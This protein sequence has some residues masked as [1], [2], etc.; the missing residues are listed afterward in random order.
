[1]KISISREGFY[2]LFIVLMILVGSVIREVNPMLLFAAFLCAPLVIAWRL[3]RRSLRGLQVRR[4]LPMQIFAGEPFIVHLE[5]TNPK[6]NS[7]WSLSSWGIVVVD[8]IQ[9]LY[10]NS[11]EKQEK[12]KPYEPAVYFEYIPNG[13][14]RK[15]SY[16][17][18]LPQRGRYKIGPA[19]ISTRFPF[20]FFRH[21]MEQP[22]TNSE[23]T[24]F[25]VYPKLGKLSTQWKTRQHEANEN[26]QRNR[27]RPTRVSGEFLGVRGWQR[28]D[29]KR[30]IHWRAWA[31]HQE[32]VV[33]QFEQNQ[34]RDC[35]VLIDLYQQGEFN[36][37]QRENFELA[38]SFT[39]TL[40]SELTRRGGC[41]L[42]FST[43][44]GYNDYLYGLICLP[45]VES[46]LYRLAL[47][48]PSREDGLAQTLFKAI[49]Q[50]DP[51]AELI[52]ITPASFN[53]LQSPRFQE[54]QAD[55]RFRSLLQRIRV[56]DTSSNDLETI[57]SV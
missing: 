7:W 4:I 42:F 13:Q 12:I 28:G 46:I 54:Y 8:R 47:A 19:M 35:A 14:T 38:I 34:N 15:K 9:P 21:W 57:F 45:I 39:A 56:I 1:M 5:A 49:S 23:N 53:L 32:P 18:R 33:R 37:V 43:N 2:F 29:S 30:W 50:I 40:V 26:Q 27:Y 44:T 10:N 31:K 3:G 11:K 16:A 24:E 41:N 48:E 55:P 17:G 6:P 22:D 36:E 52:L 51:S 25:C 20:G